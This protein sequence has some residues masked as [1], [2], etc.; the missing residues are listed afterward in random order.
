MITGTDHNS[1][2]ASASLDTWDAEPDI[3]RPD[4]VLRVDLDGFEGP[5]DLLL[6]LARTHKLDIARISILALAEQYLGFIAQTK[7]LR[8]ELAADYL[9]MAAWLAFLK[10][11]LMLPKEETPDDEPTG[12]EL[13]A[14]LAFRLRRLEAMRQAAASLAN[15][16]RL[17]R[18]VFAR[19]MPEGVRKV[20][21]NAW[22]ANVYDLLAAYARQRQR[23]AVQRITFRARPVWSLK[24]ARVRIERLLG[25][26][27]SW[28]PINALIMQALDDPS[29]RRT[30]AAS[31]FGASLEMAREGEVELRQLAAFEPLYLRRRMRIAVAGGTPA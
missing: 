7:S 6:S 29:L 16:K 31:T 20:R 11:R 24:D 22:D 30:A 23:N 17:G 4:E 9:V 27:C 8:M 2:D 18:D 10:T 13:A 21:T 15:R 3:R 28:A 25:M 19:G 14:Q 26:D 12:E 1:L 5:L